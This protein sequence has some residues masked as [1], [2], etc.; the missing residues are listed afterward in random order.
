MS[1]FN[2]HSRLLR[3]TLL[4]MVNSGCSDDNEDADKGQHGDPCASIANCSDGLACEPTSDPDVGV[5]AEPVVVS[6]T[7]SDALTND[8][9]GD[10]LVFLLDASGT[11]IAQARTDSEGKFQLTPA[12]PRVSA[13]VP[14]DAIWT[15]SISASGYQPFPFGVRTPIPLSA[16]QLEAAGG[17][18]VLSDA[19]T[20]VV[21]LPLEGARDLSIL[22]GQIDARAAGALIVAESDTIPAPFGMVGPTGEFTIFN[23]E[24]SEVTVRGYRK[25]LNV[26]P[27]AVTVDDE[28]ENVE[29]S[30]EDGALGNVSG[31]INIV[32][33]AGGS[34]SSVVLVPESVFDPLSLKGPV[35]VGLRVPDAPRQPNVS[36]AFEF[37]DVS[38]GKYVVLA[39]FE[40]DGLVRDPDT[41]IGGTTL[42]TLEVGTTSV[43][44]DESF[45]VT[46]A[47]A[48]VSPGSSGIETVATAP[49][50]SWEDD[51]SED[52]YSFVLRSALGEVIWEQPEVRGV[53]G[54]DAVSLEYAGPA[55]TPGMFYQFQV[56]S[57]RDTNDGPV[58][59]SCTEDLRGVFRLE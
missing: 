24:K 56:T 6:G 3:W 4:L 49:T 27:R 38:P 21:L 25:G 44:L 9:I 28:V 48:V 23:V 58:P 34:V 50:F 7:V 42:Q 17:K 11:P 22:E 30:L 18:L 37:E 19:N 43:T 5:C 8:P 36:G 39:A 35:P 1:Q 51:S 14:D 41:N 16:D 54:S 47:L 13:E 29:L 31:S 53:S 52:Y 2:R 33:A 10:G 15:L 40:N 57:M 26:E 12:V 45:K 20:D 46:G 32:N 59:I 55:L